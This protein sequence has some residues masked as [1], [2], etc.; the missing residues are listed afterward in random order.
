MFTNLFRLN[1][2][3]HTIHNFLWRKQILAT[4]LY[5][6]IWGTVKLLGTRPVG[7]W[8]FVVKVYLPC[9]KVFFRRHLKPAMCTWA[10][11]WYF[12]P[13][14][15]SWN[16]KPTLF[17]DAASGAGIVWCLLFIIMPFWSCLQELSIVVSTVTNRP[18]QREIIRYGFS[19]MT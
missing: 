6:H 9:G 17:L 15:C 8:I 1:H 16:C 2:V 18:T 3:G 4:G 13:Q 10:S 11:I 19:S 14:W 5:W 7:N 12:S